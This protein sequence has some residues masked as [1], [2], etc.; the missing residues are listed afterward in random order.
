MT[1]ECNFE[2]FTAP[3]S[4]E[5]FA[6]IGSKFASASSKISSSAS[7]SGDAVSSDDVI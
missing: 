1:A 4:G 6:S 2:L 5:K 3:I 7:L